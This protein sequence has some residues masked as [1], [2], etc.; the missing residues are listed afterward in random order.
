MSASTS[1]P[2]AVRN[3]RRFFNT[4]ASIAAV[5][6]VDVEDDNEDDDDNDDDAGGCRVSGG[7]A[8]SVDIMRCQ[9]NLP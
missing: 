2:S 1:A 7:A 5:A 6:G 4:T 3:E 8:N 9:T